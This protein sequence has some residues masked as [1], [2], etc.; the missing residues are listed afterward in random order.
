MKR[1]IIVLIGPIGSGKNTQ[2][3]LLADKFGFV[4]LET[5]KIIEERLKKV[6]PK[7]KEMVR[8]KKSL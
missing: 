3:D 6:N 5:S 2:A 4:H 8:A 7:D 1:G